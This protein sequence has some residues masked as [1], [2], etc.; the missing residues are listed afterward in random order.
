MDAI[1]GHVTLQIAETRYAIKCDY[2]PFMEWLKETCKDFLVE[3]EPH[4]RINL[5][6]DTINQEVATELNLG[7]RYDDE[8]TSFNITWPCVENP[9]DTYRS[10]LRLFLQLSPVSIQQADL[11]VH[12]SAVIHNGEAFVFT[13]PSGAGKTTICD[14]LSAKEGFTILHDDVVILSPGVDGFWA[15]SSPLHGQRPASRS[16]SAPLRALFFIHQAKFNYVSRLAGRNVPGLISQGTMLT[17]WIRTPDGRL[18]NNTRSTLNLILL[19]SESIPCYEL[20]F[21]PDFSFWDL[22]ER[23]LEEKPLKRSRVSEQ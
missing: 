11:F 3:G 22:I 1:N 15:W 18:I 21:K 4:A 10:M 5:R 2:L 13:G 12:A 17:P 6:F 16:I 14:I 8:S 23:A 9:D 20:H 19:L 7:H